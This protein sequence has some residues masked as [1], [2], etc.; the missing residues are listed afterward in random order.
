MQAL[1][2]RLAGGGVER[3]VAGEVRTIAV[4]LA[5]DRR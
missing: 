2:W 1:Q 3:L 5:P 4:S